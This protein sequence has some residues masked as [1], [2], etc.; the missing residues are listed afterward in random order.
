MTKIGF[1]GL[2]D[3]SSAVVGRAIAGAEG[4]ADLTALV[5]GD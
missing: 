4:L 5:L 3:K 1:I 2:G